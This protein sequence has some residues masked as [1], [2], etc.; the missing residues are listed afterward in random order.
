[1]MPPLLDIHNLYLHYADRRGA[2]RAVDGVSFALAGGGHALGIVGESGSGKSSLAAAIMRMLPGNVARFDGEIYLGGQEISRLPDA[3]F[4]REI[5]WRKIALVPQGAMNGFNPVV[6]VGE[7]IIEPATVYGDMDRRTARHKAEELLARVGLPG[8]V[9]NRYPHELSGGM[10]QR[11]MIAAALI[12]SPSL[13]ILDEPT[14]ALDV[15]VQAQIMNLLKELK[16]ELGLSII[17]I[18][19]DIALASDLC[20]SLAVVYAGE[21]VELG[22]AE[23]MLMAPAHPYS[24]KLLASIPRLHD[25]QMPEFIPGSPPDLR[26]P[27]PGCRFHLRCP[28]VFGRCKEEW[29]TPFYPQ[30]GQMARCWLLDR[31][32]SDGA[33]AG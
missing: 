2:V 4:R 33:D 28:A 16:Q 18:T 6:R 22:T 14:S 15:S 29:P 11:A 20:D 5:R 10:K 31:S 25:A 32:E 30:P 12:L 24:Q 26:Q 19:H 21:I 1:M 9:Y 27:P 23:Q 7:Q 3:S 17:F 13:V 8:E